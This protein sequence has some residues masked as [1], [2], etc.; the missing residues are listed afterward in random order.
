[1]EKVGGGGGG[2]FHP[3]KKPETEWGYGPL[4]TTPSQLCGKPGTGRLIDSEHTDK[5]GP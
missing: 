3:P 4:T 2:G 5:L 1:M